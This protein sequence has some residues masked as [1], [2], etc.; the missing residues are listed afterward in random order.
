MEGAV[1]ERGPGATS[2]LQDLGC[3]PHPVSLSLLLCEMKVESLHL[4]H[5]FLQRVLLITAPP[6][7]RAAQG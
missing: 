2:Q 5:R 1:G 7:P 3:V 4:P 6:S